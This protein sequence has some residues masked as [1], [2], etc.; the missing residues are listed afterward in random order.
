MIFYVCGCLPA[1]GLLSD[2][3]GSG[4]LEIRTPIISIRLIAY[5]A[6]FVEGSQYIAPAITL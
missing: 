2:D 5:A 4:S 6:G 1:L 3:L